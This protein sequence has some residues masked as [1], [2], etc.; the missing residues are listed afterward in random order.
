MK[1][2]HLQIT[3]TIRIREDFNSNKTTIKVRT[4]HPYPLEKEDIVL[5]EG[6]VSDK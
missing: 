1:C 5:P 6:R 4:K 3:I 2:P